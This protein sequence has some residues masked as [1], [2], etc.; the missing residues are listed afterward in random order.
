MGEGF[1][2]KARHQIRIRRIYKLFKYSLPGI[3]YDE[4]SVFQFN[5]FRSPRALCPRSNHIVAHSPA[6]SLAH[7]LVCA[8]TSA[9]FRRFV[10]HS[11]CHIVEKSRANHDDPPSMGKLARCNLQW[12]SNFCITTGQRMSERNYRSWCK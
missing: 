7:S 12:N 8:R 9:A 1:E 4:Y 10:I 6:R 2:A 5:P 11:R 3:S